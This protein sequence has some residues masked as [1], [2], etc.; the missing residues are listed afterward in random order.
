MK[1]SGINGVY[2]CMH[3]RVTEKERDISGLVF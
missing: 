1:F 2:V 3:V